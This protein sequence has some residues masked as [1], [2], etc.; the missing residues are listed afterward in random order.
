MPNPGNRNNN[1]EHQAKPVAPVY[2]RGLYHFSR[3]IAEKG[4]NQ[5][6]PDGYMEAHIQKQQAP[7]ILVQVE[8]TE[9]DEKGGSNTATGGN[10]IVVMN[11]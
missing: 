4:V 2:P 5:P 1:T 10:K 7:G 3:N 9:D 8:I 6:N 11:Q